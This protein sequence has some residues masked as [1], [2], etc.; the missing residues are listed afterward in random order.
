MSEFVKDTVER[1]V[2]TFV[3][4]FVGGLGAVQL[5]DLKAVQ[6]LALAAGVAALSVVSSA[7]SKRFGNK[8]SASLV[9]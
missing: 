1:A 5:T 4:T 2:K 9:S 6:A 3:Q 7:L 8:D